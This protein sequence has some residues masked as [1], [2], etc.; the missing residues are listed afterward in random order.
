MTQCV[1]LTALPEYLGLVFSTYMAAHA[2]YN[3]S[4]KGSDALFSSGIYGYCMQV[5]QDT[6]Q[7]NIQI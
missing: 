3:S 5:V 1:R 7:A 4:F 6:Q 2:I